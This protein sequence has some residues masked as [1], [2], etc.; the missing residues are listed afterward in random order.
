LKQKDEKKFTAH[1][2]FVAK[3]PKFEF[4]RS[5]LFSLFGIPILSLG[6]VFICNGVDILLGGEYSIP[7]L[8]L[9]LTAPDVRPSLSKKIM[10]PLLLYLAFAFGMLLTAIGLVL[11]LSSSKFTGAVASVFFRDWNVLIS[12]ILVVL[13]NLWGQV[14]F[15]TCTDGGYH[16]RA[17]IVITT[18]A[19]IYLMSATMPFTNY[20]FFFLDPQKVVTSIVSHGLK[21]VMQSVKDPN[22]HHVDLY[23]HKAVSAIEHLTAAANRAIRKV[24]IHCSKKHS[25]LFRKTRTLLPSQWMHCVLLLF[26]MVDIK[27]RC[28]IT[29]TT[30]L[31]GSGNV[32]N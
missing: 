30:F 6:L 16:P 23:Q 5:L 2:P 14:V 3:P 29:G 11:E 10:T 24:H 1:D 9:S 15:M 32:C 19:T 18:G 4:P 20:L 17:S 12:V 26:T 13:L 8:V 22:G 21:G 25:T 27:V 7:E 31:I 28:L